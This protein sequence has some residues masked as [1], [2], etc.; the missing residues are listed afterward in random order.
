[1]RR[2]R[3]MKSR[4][5]R[6]SA[7]GWGVVCVRSTTPMCIWPATAVTMSCSLTRSSRDEDLAEAPAAVVLAGEGAVQLL[8]GDQAAGDEQGAQL[9]AAGGALLAA[10]DQRVELAAAARPARKGLVT[11]SAA[12]ARCACSKVREV[13]G[14]RESTISGD[15]AQGGVAGDEP[16]QLEG[17]E[18]SRGRGRAR[19]PPAACR[20]ASAG[21]PGRRGWRD[22]VAWR[23]SDLASSSRSSVSS[24]MIARVF[25]D[26]LRHSDLPPGQRPV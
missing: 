16:Q 20:A 7:A 10:A 26:V 23:R 24:S 2:R 12:P 3:T 21:C 11:N 4:G 13:A 14:R 18:A 6:P 25:L 1:M 15:A 5:S 19:S 9:E 17:V 22:V 8:L